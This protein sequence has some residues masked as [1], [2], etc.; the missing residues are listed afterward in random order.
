[1]PI[2]DGPTATAQSLTAAPGRLRSNWAISALGLGAFVLGSAEIVVVGLLNL[3]AKDMHVSLGTAGTLVT[4]YA[5]GISIGGPILASLSIR[6]DRRLL[7]SLSLAAYV[8]ANTLAALAVTFG[9]LIAARI[10]MGSIHGVFIG[11]AF[12]VAAGLVPPERRGRAI[13]M[14]FAGVAMSAAVGLPLG[15]LLGQAMGWQAAFV[16]IVVVGIVALACTVAF[17]PSMDGGAPRA[18]AAQARAAFAPR[19]L[20]VLAIGF[21]VMG[22]Q[23]TALTYLTPYLEQVTGVSGPL[24]SGFLLA[25]GT[26]TAVGSILGGRAADR[27][28]STTLIVANVLLVGALVA[29]YFLGATPILAIV[30]LCAWG[31][32]GYGLVPSLQLRVIS[33]AGP[34]ADLAATLPASAITAGI[35][36]GALIGGW[37][38]ANHGV[39]NVV[40]AS[41]AMCALALPVAWATAGFS[42]PAS[43]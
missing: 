33:L 42:A 43:G 1:M 26:A 8:A 13:S 22:G 10:L 29:L 7:L 24:V 16:A 3:I 39:S 30:A 25:F 14:V 15:T 12:R 31:L 27:S 36:T 21:L 38:V 9:M 37:A 35:A 11:A 19:V 34:G 17:V 41:A 6:L 2:Q 23:F 20:A 18:F 28:A 32:V 5:L 40:V 4:A